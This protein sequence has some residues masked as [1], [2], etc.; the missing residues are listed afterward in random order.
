MNFSIFLIFVVV[1]LATV[2][3]GNDDTKYIKVDSLDRWKV[4]DEHSNIFTPNTLNNDGNGASH[5]VHVSDNKGKFLKLDYSMN[6]GK[7]DSFLK[8][9]SDEHSNNIKSIS[10]SSNN[11][12]TLYF[13]DVITMNRYQTLITSELEMTNSKKSKS[14]S[15]SSYYI[16]G[17][18]SWKCRDYNV[19]KYYPIMRRIKSTVSSDFSSLS[20]V[21]SSEHASYMDVFENLDMKFETNMKL[22]HESMDTYK[23]MAGK[24]SSKKGSSNNN[25]NND[26]SNNGHREKAAEGRRL[27]SWL[28]DAWDVC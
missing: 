10:C 6:H 18:H 24:T 20:I 3:F 16:V 11:D 15:K 14:Q 17:S 12:M 13:N 5:S 25:K 26:N 19:N 23:Q 4:S 8:L 28:S 1:A 22:S 9:E 2:T 7:H 27:L 21:I